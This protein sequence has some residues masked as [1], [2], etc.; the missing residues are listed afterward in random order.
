MIVALSF[1]N[2][3][4]LI[5]CHLLTFCQEIFIMLNVFSTEMELQLTH[6]VSGYSEDSRIITNTRT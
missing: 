4:F 1:E 6:G 3:F 2:L 5:D